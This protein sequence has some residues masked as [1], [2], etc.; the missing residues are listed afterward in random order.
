MR[1]LTIALAAS[2][3]FA[4]TVVLPI[5]IELAIA[6]AKP[7]PAKGGASVEIGNGKKIYEASCAMCHGA[8]SVK[9]PMLP[10]A[11]NFF[12]GQF[13][14]TKGNSKEMDK[15]IKIGG[16]AYGKGLTAQMPAQP[17]LSD[18]DRKD[19]VAFIKTLKGK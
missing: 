4:L 1:N 17:Q 3:P 15:L 19:V 18:Q 13:K 6:A 7:T 12:A 16:A 14:V 2:L 10:N 8:L 9:K 11:A 5:T